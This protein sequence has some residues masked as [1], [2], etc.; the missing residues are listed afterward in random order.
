[1]KE[2]NKPIIMT[3]VMGKADFA[4]ADRMRRRHFPVERNVIAAHVTLFHHLPP[5]AFSEIREAVK[6]LCREHRPP[7]AHLRGLLH[8]GR[9]VA[10]QIE[11]PQ[12][13]AMRMNLAEMFHGLLVAQDQQTP[14][15]HVTVQ[16]KVTPKEAKSLLQSLSAEFEPRPFEITGLGLHYY[17]DGPWQEIGEW[18]FR[19]R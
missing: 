13:L 15:L 16:N 11:S 3:A 19:G 18:T 12:L 7:D 17:M 2:L 9:G 10:Y 8:L 5:Q 1:M 4:W 14:R 6:E